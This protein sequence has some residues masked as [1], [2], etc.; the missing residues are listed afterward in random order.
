[1]SSLPPAKPYELLAE[2]YDAVMAHVD[3][4]GWAALVRRIWK[5]YQRSP[6]RILET[7]AGTCRLA[8][9]LAAP[10]RRIVSTDI[11]APMLACGTAR[12]RLRACGDFRALPFADDSFDAILC[13][14][15]AVNYCLTE[16]DL[17][18]FFSE[19]R[20]VLEPGGILLFDATT[21]RNSRL[22]FA[23]VVFHEVHGST[24]VIRHSWYDGPSR[25]QHNDFTFFHPLRDGT[26]SRRQECHVQRVWQRQA[27][28]TSCK[29][30]GLS[31]LTIL[32]DDLRAAGPDTLRLH[33]VAIAP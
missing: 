30:A 2:R 28:V 19:A 3:Y 17:N 22:N 20:R 29:R 21:G 33:M 5:L 10:G 16:N 31:P 24:E 25:A 11:S 4:P 26:Y 12:S 14:Y 7:G 32:N 23:D 6:R 1:L 27:F 9:F 8:P 15:D 13:L 18:A